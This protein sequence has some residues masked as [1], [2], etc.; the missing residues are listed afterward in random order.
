M[1]LAHVTIGKAI[2]QI[3]LCALAVGIGLYFLNPAK[4][5][6]P[7]AFFAVMLLAASAIQKASLIETIQ[8]SGPWRL[9]LGIAFVSLVLAVPIGLNWREHGYVI[10][11]AIGLIVFVFSM[12]KYLQARFESHHTAK[13]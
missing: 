4:A 1:S 8:K 3:F 9:A 6:F 2:G 7:T 5:S 12:T 13:S 11:M 10:P